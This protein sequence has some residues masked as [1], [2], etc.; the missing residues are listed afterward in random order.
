MKGRIEEIPSMHSIERR[1]YSDVKH[2]LLTIQVKD[3][4]D[5]TFKS[6]KFKF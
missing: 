6:K 2:N 1:F 5:R 4:L 3:T